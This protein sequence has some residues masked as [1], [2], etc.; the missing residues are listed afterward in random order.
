VVS[1]DGTNFAPGK[2]V[3]IEATVHVWPGGPTADRLDLYSAAN[4]NS[5]TWAAVATSITPTASQ[6]GI[7]TFTRTYTLPSGG[8]QAVRAQFRYQGSASSCTSGAYNDRDDLV[9][10]VGGA[11][12]ATTVFEDNFTNSLGWTTNPNG[13]DTATTGAWQRGDPQ[14]TNSNGVKQL[15]AFSAVNDLATGLSAGASAGDFDIDGGVT[16]IQSPAITMPSTG[17]LTLSFQY[18]LAHGSN[19]SSADFFRAFVVVGATPT[20]V[21]QSLGAAS[22]RNGVWT[23]VSNVSLNAYAGQTIRIRFDAADAST[24]SLVEAG[25]DDVK[26]TQQ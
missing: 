20:Q 9:F 8:L 17:T 25:V 4:A 5:P 16:S 18:Y 23:A 15:D 6:G 19:S 11:P 1:V 10:A 7:Q 21:F 14:P 13:T 22:N 26:I 2:Q 3:R 12:P 24:A